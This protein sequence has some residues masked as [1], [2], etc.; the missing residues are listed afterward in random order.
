MDREFIHLDALIVSQILIPYAK[1]YFSHY[2]NMFFPVQNN[3]L[4]EDGKTWFYYF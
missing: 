1:R 2:S 4:M 3:F